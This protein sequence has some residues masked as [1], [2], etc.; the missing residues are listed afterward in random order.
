VVT[1][2]FRIFRLRYRMVGTIKAIVKP[3]IVEVE[4]LAALPQIADVL[5]KETFFAPGEPD[6]IVRDYVDGDSLKRIHWKATAAAG[7]LKVRREI[8]EEK[9]GITLFLDTCRHDRKIEKHLPLESKMLEVLLALGIFFAKRNMSVS[10]YC[11]QAETRRLDVGSVCGFEDFYGQVSE[12]SFREEERVE[13]LLEELHISGAVRDSKVF[14]GIVHKVNQELLK[15]ADELAAGGCVVV[16]YAVTDENLEAY[17]RENTARRRL[18][19]I[20][21]EAELEGL[22]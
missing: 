3:K 14:I 2:F 6:V 7:Q 13:E 8:G 12:L 19:V 20:P 22:L 16:L 18:V 4:E 21:T 1:D 9:R 10:A 15:L 5:P 11:K 17:V